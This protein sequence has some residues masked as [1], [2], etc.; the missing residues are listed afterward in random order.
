M[1]NRRFLIVDRVVT[2]FTV[3]ITVTVLIFLFIPAV[4]VVL[5]AFSDSAYYELPPKGWGLRQF[6]MLLS[7]PEWILSL[8]SSLQIASV[9]VVIAVITI[10]P[11]ILYFRR[12]RFSR[13]QALQVVLLAPLVLPQSAYA[14]ALYIVFSKIGLLGSWI[15]LAIAQGLLAIPL[16]VMV[17]SAEINRLSPQYEEAAETLGGRS[18]QVWRDVTLPLLAPAIVAAAVLG[19]DSAFNDATFASFLSGVHVVTLPKRILDAVRFGSDPFVTGV[20]AVLVILS[21]I[22]GI[23]SSL[24]RRGR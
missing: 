24:L 10:L 6:R 15:G 8:V 14:V 13:L 17:L 16:F 4:V 1:S 21:V 22:L 9:A 11:L 3:L 23:G 19:F 12:Q 2:R 5:L 7:R 18:F 20:A